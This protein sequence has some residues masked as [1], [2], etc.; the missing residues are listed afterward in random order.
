[1]GGQQ[2]SHYKT[3]IRAYHSDQKLLRRSD[4][5]QKETPIG[6]F[7]KPELDLASMVG[8]TILFMLHIVH[9][10]TRNSN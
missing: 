1:M 4:C 3:A 8:P 7:V 6:S 5:T 9:S 2:L 10:C